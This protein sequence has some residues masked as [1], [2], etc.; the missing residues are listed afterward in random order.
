MQAVIQSALEAS[1]PLMEAK[2]HKLTVNMPPETLWLHADLTRMAQVV[3]NLL[4]NATKYTAESGCIQLDVRREGNEVIID[5]SDNGLGLRPDMLGKIFELFTQVES[6]LEQ[7]QGGLGI[8][9]ALVKHLVEMHS[10]HIGVT[11]PGLG[12]G[13]TFFVRLPLAPTHVREAEKGEG[14]EEAGAAASLRVLVVD[15]NLA[16]AKTTGWMLEMNGHT[17]SLAHDGPEA[18][19]RAHELHP[20]VVLLDIGLPGMNG[21]DVCRQLRKDPVFQNTVF[22]AQTGWGQKRDKE[23]AQEAG[24]DHHLIKPIN[25]EELSGLLAKIKL[26]A[27]H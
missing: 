12:K 24:F 18:L 17:P 2:N 15:D 23:M 11:S 19:Q 5:V 14:A 10:G 22:I 20:H 7:S 8:G 4:N 1:R 16:S 27:Y 13:S 6:S 25:F 21:Y 3:S 9:L 26:P